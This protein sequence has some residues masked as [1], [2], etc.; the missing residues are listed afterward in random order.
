MAHQGLPGRNQ[1]YFLRSGEGERYAF[2]NAIATV[3]AR[4]E[5][6]GGRY[7]ASFVFGDKARIVPFHRHPSAHKIYYVYDGL[8][9]V[10]LQGGRRLLARGDFISLPPQTAHDVEFLTHRTRILEMAMGGDAVG[11]YKLLGEPTQYRNPPPNGVAINAE[12]LNAAATTLGL[13]IDPSALQSPPERHFDVELPEGIVPYALEAG[14]GVRLVAADQ[15]F[16]M[17]GLRRNTTQDFF[18]VVCEGPTGKRIPE[19][20]HSKHSE[21]FVGVDGRVSMTADGEEVMLYPG[22]F[23][24]VAAGTRHTYKLED[25][26]T[27][28]FSILTPGVFEPFFFTLG[29][30]YQP[31]IFPQEPGAL[32]IDRV[33]K[34]LPT[35][36][37]TFTGVAG[38]GM[39]SAGWF[40][41]T[42]RK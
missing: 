42:F 15:V 16:T 10:G 11:L 5:D 4:Y 28:F 8:V 27:R 33:M 35:L 21:V 22:D 38:V 6:T 13:E 25:P 14:N 41:R 26:F 3:V 34:N 40:L 36:D 24:Q 37:V 1:T 39:R 9:A 32:R 29:D 17:L 19:H 18:V 7:Q 2:G 31:Y 20:Y 30:P 12:R 23:L